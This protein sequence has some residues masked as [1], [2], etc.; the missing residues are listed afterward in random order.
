MKQI[1]SGTR[2]NQCRSFRT[3]KSSLTAHLL[4]GLRTYDEAVCTTTAGYVFGLDFVDRKRLPCL[5]SE[6]ATTEPRN[7]GPNNRGHRARACRLFGHVE[8][9]LHEGA[10]CV[11]QSHCSLQ[12]NFNSRSGTHKFS[13][14]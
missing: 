9:Q 7:P 11:S 2:F 10:S 6:P 3:I 4:E 14:N 12:A 13:A 8:I 1:A 5:C